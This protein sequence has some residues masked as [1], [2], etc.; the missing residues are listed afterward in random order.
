MNEYGQ[1]IETWDYEWLNVDLSD[2]NKA[3]QDLLSAGCEDA[4]MIINS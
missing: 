4:E 3:I 2:S 1:I